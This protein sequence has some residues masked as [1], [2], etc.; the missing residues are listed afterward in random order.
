M[1]L[2][3]I[4]DRSWDSFYKLA[5]WNMTTDFDL[6]GKYCVWNEVALVS[7]VWRVTSPQNIF[8][9]LGVV[10][11]NSLSLCYKLQMSGILPKKMAETRVFVYYNDCGEKDSKKKAIIEKA[12]AKFSKDR[13]KP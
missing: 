3:Y 10:N 13:K 6:Y 12:F 5:A 7:V 4:H 2:W 9:Y 11:N 8:I 1:A